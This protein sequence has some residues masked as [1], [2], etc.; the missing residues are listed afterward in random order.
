MRIC[1]GKFSRGTNTRLAVSGVQLILPLSIR[2]SIVTPSYNQGR[3]LNQTVESVLHQN[4]PDLEYLVLDGGSTDDSRE[5]L[6]RH[7]DRLAFWCSEPDGG[8]YHAINAGFARS[9]GEVLG[10]LNSDDMYLPGALSVVAEIFERY[11]QIEW[12]TTLYPL[13]WDTAGRVVRCSARA[14]FSRAGFMAGESLPTGDWYSPG[15]LQQESTFWRRSLWERVGA[16]LD[17]RWKIAADFDLW[18]R[19]S[20]R[21]ELY[22]V[23]VP[24]GGFRL[25]GDQKTA[26]QRRE[27]QREAEEILAAH[28]GHTPGYWRSSL[29]SAAA[30]LCPE[31]LRSLVG[32]MGLLHS[33]KLCLRKRDESGWDLV[34]GWC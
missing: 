27:Y 21:A 12:L 20:E 5:I 1:S 22:A 6:R 19:F 23:D 10:W 28:G 11:P 17:T 4:V 14:G 3:F 8:Q 34:D 33:C 25:H 13:R 29:R 2:I 32:G 31:S 18:L 26:H 9:T 30:R 16:K 24:L 15:W 7:G